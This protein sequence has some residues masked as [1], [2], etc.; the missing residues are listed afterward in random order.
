[1]TRTEKAGIT[2]PVGRVI[3]YLKKGRY[4]KRIGVGAGVYLASVLEYLTAEV[5]ELAG[6]AARDLKKKRVIPRHLQL[7]IRNDDELN[8]LLQGVTIAD[9]GVIPHVHA[10]L[11]PKKS[12]T[13]RDE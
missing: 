12:T 8:K 11:L 2:F 7:A 3:K 4:A 1:M 9:G 5:L 13:R 10:V 6:N